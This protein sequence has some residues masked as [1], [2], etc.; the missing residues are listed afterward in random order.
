MEMGGLTPKVSSSSTWKSKVASSSPP[1]VQTSQNPLRYKGWVGGGGY[2]L[3]S[4][5][6]IWSC[7]PRNIERGGVGESISYTHTSPPKNYNFSL[8]IIIIPLSLSLSCRS[9]TGSK[10]INI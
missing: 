4:V 1:R 6:T 7:K 9:R 2:K 3:L 8:L 10:Y 5:M